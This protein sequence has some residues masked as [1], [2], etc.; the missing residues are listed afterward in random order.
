MID[1]LDRTI[2]ELLRREL[3]PSIVDQVAITFA[4]PDGDFPPSSVPT[5]DLFLYDVRENTELRSTEWTIERQ[6]NGVVT[7]RRPPVRVECSY[8]I[9]AWSNAETSQRAFDEHRLLSEVMVVL[10]R[11]PTLPP[12]IL[13]R[14]LRE[15]QPKMLPSCTLN[16]GHL[17]SVA[18]FWQ[19]LGGR[20]KAALHYAVTIAIET[21]KAVEAETVV[22]EKELQYA[23]EGEGTAGDQ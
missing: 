23:L 12:S 8:L 19:I 1:D 20:P 17:Q 6:A 21:G 13:Q 4:A 18:E 14:S 7:R 16:P 11:H 2:E 9:T 10:L 15:Q 3:P 22:L 5:I